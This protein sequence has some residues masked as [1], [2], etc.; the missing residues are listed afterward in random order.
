MKKIFMIS[1]V[2]LVLILSACSD[3]L[4]HIAYPV[5]LPL[6]SPLNEVIQFAVAI[7]PQGV[8]HIV[9]IECPA[10]TM[11][12]CKMIY[13]TYP[14]NSNS[15]IWT[16]APGYS[17]FAPDIAVDS[18]GQ[19]YIVVGQVTDTLPATAKTAWV[20]PGV[21]SLNFIT[22]DYT[23]AGRAKVAANGSYV[24]AVW[25]VEDGSGTALRYRQ[26]NILDDSYGYA[27]DFPGDAIHRS[28]FDIAVSSNGKLH[29]TW[30]SWPD[31]FTQSI[32]YT[33]NVNTG[34]DMIGRLQTIQTAS[35]LGKPFIAVDPT[36][37]HVYVAYDKSTGIMKEEKYPGDRV[38]LW[39]CV[40]DCD[41]TPAPTITQL[42]NISQDPWSLFSDPSLTAS[43]VDDR[44]YVAISA[45]NSE[46]TLGKD[47][48][49]LDY[50]FSDGVI[51]PYRL[52][53]DNSDD[54]GPPQ[55]VGI[56]DSSHTFTYAITGWRKKLNTTTYG[57][58]FVYDALLGMRQ[59]A[60]SGTGAEGME[61]ASGDHFVMGA[62]LG[63]INPHLI[64][65]HTVWLSYN[66]FAIL[67]PFIRR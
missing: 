28:S 34:G 1:A 23:T 55:V 12:D 8:R 22:N 59:V 66:D 35:G 25:E 20:K 50:H 15:R 38:N 14:A 45:I 10:G 54:D 33:S 11:E 51:T 57:D 48:F 47:I 37:T 5:A 29:V 62:W 19:A 58:V 64:S 41:G 52:S 43:R 18:S 36:N 67:M 6:S 30:R 13:Q 24:Y 2:V 4:D 17:Y 42:L 3:P 39:V 65:S 32:N 44:V 53:S 63:D 7:D 61:L 49:L 21:N 16:P 46:V 40:T 27:S 9:S 60:D 26:L 31:E 56:T